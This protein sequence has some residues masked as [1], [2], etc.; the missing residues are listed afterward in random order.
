MT[1]TNE[2]NLKAVACHSGTE[3]TV[4]SKGKCGSI[5]FEAVEAESEAPIG[6]NGNQ[7]E[8]GE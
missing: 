4:A 3:I 5:V 2:C 6:G 1:Y 7:Q 8:N